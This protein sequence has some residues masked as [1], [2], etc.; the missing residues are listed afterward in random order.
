MKKL[1]N[2]KSK[3]IL[4]MKKSVLVIFFFLSFTGN[5]QHG[6]LSIVSN[7]ADYFWVYINGVRVNHEPSFY[8]IN[9]PVNTP[10]CHVRIV[11]KNPRIPAIE[12]TVTLMDPTGQ[13]YHVS[14][15]LR[16]VKRWLYVMNDA[17]ATY[18]TLL[19][20]GIGNNIPMQG[21]PL[22]DIQGHDDRINP[23]IHPSLPTQPT[24]PSP[25]PAT[26][27]CVPM[28]FSDFEAAKT[29]I[30]KANFDDTK[31]IIAKQIASNN[32]LT[33]AQ[34]RDIMKLFSFESTR[35]E[36]AKFAYSHCYDKGNYFMVNDAFSFSSS[37]EELNEFIYGH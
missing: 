11:F 6:L 27:N 34:I 31:L 3:M 18:E 17:D 1:K 20:P 23:S 29:Q 24:M 4:F 36:F 9:T 22:L 37:I 12:K 33:A 35:L 10:Y 13:W 16:K 26:S 28:Y 14:F 15:L 19:I 2:K 30:I 25:T 7:G 8:V 21:Q 5:A 32:C